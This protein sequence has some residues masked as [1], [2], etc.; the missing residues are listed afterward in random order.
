[1]KQNI[2]LIATGV[3]NLGT[4]AADFWAPPV[5]GEFLSLATPIVTSILVAVL[6]L[7]GWQDRKKLPALNVWI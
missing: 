4:L 1:M 5:V 6:A 2:V 3:L 7:L